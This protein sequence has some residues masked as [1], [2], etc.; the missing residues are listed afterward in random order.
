MPVPDAIFE[1]LAEDRYLP[2]ELAVGPWDPGA[3][4]GGAPAAL[5]AGALERAVAGAGLGVEF[6][7]SRLTVELQ[8]P[9]PVS[10]LRVTT[11]IRRPGRRICLADAVLATT[12]GT[13]VLTATLQGIRRR[14]F[15]HDHPPDDPLP[16]GPETGT[17]LAAETMTGPVAFVRSGVEHRF[18]AGTSFEDPGPAIDWIRLAHP[19]VAGEEVTPLQRVAAAADFG[20]G[21]SHLFEFEE[22]LFVNPDLTIH[23]F[24]LPVGEWVCLD[25]VTRVGDE[26]VG[27]A[28]SL[29]FDERGSVGRSTQLLLVEPR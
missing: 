15:E 21:V 20:N 28:E 22:A 27:L 26:G 3:L 23:L 18:V 12:D 4:H 1:P 14:R 25:S 10:E 16:P 9:V 2:T 13:T 24:R 17:G 5:V 19:V 7:P 6:L 29:L 8:R 11:T